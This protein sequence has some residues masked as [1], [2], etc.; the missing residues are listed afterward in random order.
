MLRELHQVAMVERK[1]DHSVECAFCIKQGGGKADHPP[2]RFAVK[3]VLRFVGAIKLF[4]FRNVETGDVRDVW[5]IRL[6]PYPGKILFAQK[7]G[8]GRIGNIFQFRGRNGGA[9]PD[10]KFF[11][12]IRINQGDALVERYLFPCFKRCGDA[13][14][15]IPYFAPSAGVKIEQSRP[16]EARA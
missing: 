14:G 7:F 11:L 15:P 12:T 1:N 10:D 16:V 13:S 5:F 2:I 6:G 3:G 8:P 9:I 4:L